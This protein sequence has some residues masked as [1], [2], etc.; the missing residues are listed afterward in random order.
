[1]TQSN[2]LYH[3]TREVFLFKQNHFV[4]ETEGFLLSGW[5]HFASVDSSSFQTKRGQRTLDDTLCTLKQK[6][7]FS[8]QK[9]LTSTGQTQGK[10]AD[11]DVTFPAPRWGGLDWHCWIWF[12]RQL[13]HVSSFNISPLCPKLALHWYTLLYQTGLCS[14]YCESWALR[15]CWIVGKQS[16]H[17]AELSC[18][19]DKKTTTTKK[20]GNPSRTALIFHLGWKRLWNWKYSLHGRAA[21]RH[22][23]ALV[24][25]NCYCVGGNIIFKGKWMKRGL[26]ASTTRQE[27]SIQP[28]LSLFWFLTLVFLSCGG[29]I[30]R[31]GKFSQHIQLFSA[32]SKWSIGISKC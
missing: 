16:L 17:P 2:D 14:F 12:L 27:A 19:Q 32:K 3:I 13:H 10:K 15:H 31:K 26:K 25:G 8:L 9:L 22:L 28:Q 29:L 11:A 30:G 1:M 21:R 5:Q 6:I 4:Q 18:P 7:C 20:E 24:V 23:T